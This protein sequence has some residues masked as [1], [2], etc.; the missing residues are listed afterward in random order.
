MEEQ[1]GIMR[2]RFDAC[3]AAM[4]ASDDAF[5]GGMAMDHEQLLSGLPDSSAA[6]TLD[7]PEHFWG[8][9][10]PVRRIRQAPA[11]HLTA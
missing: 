9:W 1:A 10:K 4:R 6:H 3:R 11:R 2:H 5:A 7:T 8:H